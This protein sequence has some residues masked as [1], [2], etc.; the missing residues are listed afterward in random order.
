MPRGRKKAF[1]PI[2]DMPLDFNPMVA[3]LL[4]AWYLYTPQNHMFI[5]TA[6]EF[7][8]GSM[9]ARF[10]IRHGS[11]AKR[12]P[13]VADTKLINKPN[14][15][16]PIPNSCTEAVAACQLLIRSNHLGGVIA[17]T[18]RIVEDKVKKGYVLKEEG[19]ANV[20]DP[21]AAAKQIEAWHLARPELSN[22]KCYPKWW[23]LT[24]P[25]ATMPQEVVIKKRGRKPGVKRDDDNEDIQDLIEQAK[26]KAKQKKKEKKPDEVPTVRVGRFNLYRS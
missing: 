17:Y 14:W 7:D 10:F 9:H 13:D 4:G 16:V 12:I 22:K 5:T 3:M 23:P 24:N 11:G 19:V 20:A 18:K 1:L 21:L 6:V 15:I 8:F 2:I 25:E 26:L